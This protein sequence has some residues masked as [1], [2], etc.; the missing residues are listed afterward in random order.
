MFIIYKN[1]KPAITSMFQLRQHNNTTGVTFV[2]LDDLTFA[3]TFSGHFSN[4]KTVNRTQFLARAVRD[5]S[6]N[7]VNE[8]PQMPYPVIK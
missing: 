2:H 5:P 3:L 4:R 7:V 1:C 8:V 6:F